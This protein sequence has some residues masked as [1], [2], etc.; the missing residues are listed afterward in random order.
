MD[1]DTIITILHTIRECEVRIMDK[2]VLLNRIYELRIINDI[3]VAELSIR[4]GVSETEIRD[5][6]N[7]INQPTHPTM[8]KICKGFDME[9]NEI[10][11]TDYKNVNLM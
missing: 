10:F 5:L 6:E 1:I 3:S 4:S 8:L 7:G 2:K 11:E 9:F